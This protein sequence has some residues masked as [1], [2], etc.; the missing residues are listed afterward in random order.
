[1]SFRVKY[2]F[3][4]AVNVFFAASAGLATPLLVRSQTQV[5][6]LDPLPPLGSKS[7]FDVMARVQKDGTTQLNFSN[8]EELRQQVFPTV[9]GRALAP[10]EFPKYL[11]L[12]M[13]FSRSLA[14]AVVSYGFPRALFTVP[15]YPKQDDQTM[16]LLLQ[17]RVF[18][19]YS[20]TTN[21]YEVISENNLGYRYE[22]QVGLYDDNTKKHKFYYAD[23]QFCAICHIGQTPMFSRGAWTETNAHFPNVKAIKSIRSRMLGIPNDQ[24]KHYQGIEIDPGINIKTQA[25]D[26]EEATHSGNLRMAIQKLWREGCETSKCRAFALYFGLRAA[27]TPG[28]VL[29]PDVESSPEYANDFKGLLAQ[30]WAKWKD[31]LEL[32]LFTLQ[33]PYLSEADVMQR[34]EIKFGNQIQKAADKKALEDLL[35]NFTFPVGLEPAEVPGTPIRG[36]VRPTIFKYP[37][38]WTYETSSQYIVRRLKDFFTP[39]DLATLSQ[40]VSPNFTNLHD[41]IMKLEKD[42]DEI[43]DDK[44]LSR[45]RVLPKLLAVLNVDK[46]KIPQPAFIAENEPWGVEAEPGRLIHSKELG[47]DFRV[48]LFGHY[49]KS[50]HTFFPFNLAKAKND[51]DVLNILRGHAELVDPELAKVVPHNLPQRIH[52]RLDWYNFKP[53]ESKNPWHWMPFAS[54]DLTSTKENSKQWQEMWSQE[55]RVKDGKA[56]SKISDREILLKEIQ[57]LLDTQDKVD[58]AGKL[59]PPPGPVEKDPHPAEPADVAATH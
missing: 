52:D 40:F 56:T 27:L 42:N 1:M 11:D 34:R 28:G 17:N 3:L 57:N 2:T 47:K 18:V 53:V 8:I 26:F 54:E 10:K 32:P 9:K 49:C 7:L 31:G 45:E 29:T 46:N 44:P 51:T 23:R 48:R 50:C 21:S 39:R 5:D 4:I 55:E 35:T 16:G 36:H 20:E 37:M 41:A 19:A 24:V 59:L 14:R 33:D 15:D 13:P 38:L 58:A 22:F 30:G 43:L 25:Q 12:L 6:P